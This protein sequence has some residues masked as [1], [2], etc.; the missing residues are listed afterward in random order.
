MDGTVRTPG[1]RS[2]P[3]QSSATQVSPS[4]GRATPTKAE[5]LA[6]FQ[7]SDK[8][9]QIIHQV[10]SSQQ[11]AFPAWIRPVS[12]YLCTELGHKNL[13]PTVIAGMEYVVA[14]GGRRSRDE[15]INDNMCGLLAGIYYF[16]ILRASSMDAGYVEQSK[17]VAE[18][19][20]ILA[21]LKDARTKVLIKG[22]EEDIAWDGWQALKN[23]DFDVAIGLIN[24]NNW[25]SADWYRGIQDVLG[26]PSQG[27]A[28]GDDED[29]QVL[30]IQTRRADTMFQEKYNYL[31]EAR[32]DDYKAWK[33]KILIRIDNL[34]RS[35]D[36]M[37]VDS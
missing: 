37:E 9:A 36:N 2:R 29:D 31:S 32:Q 10:T 35:S 26:Q 20:E 21:T 3:R 13:G 12:R 14:P 24:T 28:L 23:R 5:T 8:S 27:D 7:K 4:K 25:L 11:S 17:Y 19:K 33:D 18:R 34:E 22:I 1:S 6:A 30:P 16:T 15:S